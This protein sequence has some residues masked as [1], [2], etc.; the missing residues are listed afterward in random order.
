MITIYGMLDSG[1]CYKPRLLCA[2]LGIPFCHVEV[3]M[4]DG[5]TKRPDFVALNPK[6]QVPL[7]VL[8]DGRR[9]S[10]SNAILVYLGE[11]SRFVPAEPFENARM[12]Q[13][14]FFE[15]NA[16]ELSVAMRRS[17]TVYEERRHL[18][19]P[20]RMADLLAR[21]EAALVVMERQL[22]E[23]PFLVGEEPTLADLALYAY[24]HL[25]QEGGFDLSR[26]PAI[27][28][29]L[30]RIEALPSHRP[31]TWLPEPDAA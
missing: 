23:A 20:E 26:C 16:H 18:A 14:M 22:A 6:G 29:W 17:L 8:E 24:T 1:N 19:T 2:L 5:G 3:S 10:E 25:A 7:L 21:G 15:Q 12:L 27:R 31:L 13:W 9:L 11:G 28:R 4:L 30:G